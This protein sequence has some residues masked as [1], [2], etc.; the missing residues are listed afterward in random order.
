MITKISVLSLKMIIILAAFLFACNGGNPQNQNI[1]QVEPTLADIV[2]VESSETND[3]KTKKNVSENSEN[4][5]DNEFVDANGQPKYS[6]FDVY[7]RRHTHEYPYVDVKPLF[8]GKDGLEEWMKYVVENSKFKEI[9]EENNIQRAR[10]SYEFTID[11]DG[12]VVDAKITQNNNQLMD[13]EVLRVLNTT[14]K[15]WT[16]GKHDGETLKVRIITSLNLAYMQSD[17]QE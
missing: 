11:T 2:L 15:K 4:I 7:G 14:H 6:Y 13:D 1:S 10:V 8:N 12:S 3:D 5:I 9:A 16:P 17:A